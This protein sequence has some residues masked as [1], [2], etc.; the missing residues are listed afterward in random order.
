MFSLVGSMLLALAWIFII[1]A[2]NHNLK[3]KTILQ[4]VQCNEQIA[5]NQLYFIYRLECES[6]LCNWSAPNDATLD[7]SSGIK[8]EKPCQF[9]RLYQNANLRCIL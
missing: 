1:L 2:Y 7:F 9:L 8:G 5:N 3:K 6:I 4:G